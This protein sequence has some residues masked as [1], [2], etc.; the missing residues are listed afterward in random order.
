LIPFNTRIKIAALTSLLVMFP[1]H[2]AAQ[3]SVRKAPPKATVRTKPAAIEDRVSAITY[4]VKV[5]PDGKM[6]LAVVSGL[7]G[8]N[9]RA[10]QIRTA[11]AD[12]SPDASAQHHVSIS[13]TVMIK[14]DK[15]AKMSSVI[16]AARASRV[17]PNANVSVVTPDGVSLGV[18]PDPKFMNN[19]DIRPDPTFLLVDVRADGHSYLNNEDMG[20][21]SDPQKLTSRLSE[22]FDDRA[23]TGV[24]RPGTN[25]VEKT[26]HIRVPSDARFQRV[27]DIA[28]I[29]NDMFGRMVLAVDDDNEVGVRKVIV[30]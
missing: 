14:P 6:S 17:S 20:S 11:L 13:P 19:M 1:I 27:M 15:N 3:K 8:Q 7:E 2:A 22:V 21:I 24:L 10:D 26:V 5:G 12:Y 16:E 9:I 18:A 25:E 30:E 29:V 4:E 23:K 28:N